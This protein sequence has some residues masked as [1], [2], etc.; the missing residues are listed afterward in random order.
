M[1]LN[2]CPEVGD[3]GFRFCGIWSKNRAEWMTTL[4]ACM[5]YKITVVGFYDAMGTQSVEFILNQ[6]EMQTIVCSG[7]YIEKIVNMKKDD[8][9]QHIKALIT[10]D[11][12]KPEVMTLAEK[13]GITIHTFNKVKEEGE[14]EVALAH[15]FIVPTK[16]DYYMFSYT[17]GTTGDSKGVML[18]HNNIL[19]QA[20]CALSRLNL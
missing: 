6:T 3:E 1:N 18:T 15:E 12:I 7:D 17:S 16:D 13:L 8:M 10:L 4:L 11:D 9:A 20:W 2:L 5:H 19:S 14:T